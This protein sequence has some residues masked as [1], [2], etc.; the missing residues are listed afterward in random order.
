MPADVN[1]EKMVVYLAGKM[2][3][4]EDF[5]FPRFHEVSENLRNLGFTVISPAETAGG[6]DHLPR[7][8]Y[9]RFDYAVIN[10]VDAVVVM[11]SWLDSEGAKSEVIHAH[12]VG[13]PIYEYDPETGIG[14]QIIVEKVDIMYRRGEDGFMRHT[15]EGNVSG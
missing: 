7:H 3:G 10:I 11:P 5:N 12:E 14:K 13:V 2:S 9:F 6:A 1:G 8:W 15:G 4:I